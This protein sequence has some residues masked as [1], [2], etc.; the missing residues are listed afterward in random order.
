MLAFKEETLLQPGPLT[1]L[2]VIRQGIALLSPGTA[3]GRVTF[4]AGN[5]KR[6]A[7]AVVET[8]LRT[9][10][11]P[12]LDS[13]I[14]AWREHQPR[15]V[16]PK[17]NVHKNTAKDYGDHPE[18]YA[19]V[20]PSIE[21]AVDEINRIDYFRIGLL[22]SGYGVDLGAYAPKNPKGFYSPTVESKLSFEKGVEALE[23][24]MVEGPYIETAPGTARRLAT[25]RTKTRVYE[26]AYDR[27]VA[28]PTFAAE[29]DLQRLFEVHDSTMARLA[30]WNTF[31]LGTNGLTR[32]QVAEQLYPKLVAAKA[33]VG[34]S[35][36]TLRGRLTT[37]THKAR[38]L[39]V[40]EK[41][42]A[43]LERR[44]VKKVD[45][46]YEQIEKL[47]EEYGPE[48]SYLSGEAHALE[49]QI[50]ALGRATKGIATKKAGI[51]IP[52]LKADVKA[53]KER[54]NE[55]RRRYESSGT[56]RYQLN[57]D[58]RRWHTPT[59]SEAIDTFLS[60]DLGK[61]GT[62]ISDILDTVRA[63]AFFIDAS[64]ITIQ[65][66]L[67]MFFAPL[68][69]LRHADQIVSQVFKG[70]AL[71]QIA[72]AEPELVNAFARAQGRA[73]GFAGAEFFFRPIKFVN[74]RL[75]GAVEIARYNMWKNDRQ[76]LM[77]WGH[78]V[79]V[80]EAEAASANSK[81][82]PALNV[83]ERGISPARARV[84]RAPVV[85]PSFLLS[86]GLLMKDAASGLV[87][88]SLG[89]VNPVTAWTKLAGREQLALFRIM[90]FAGTTLSLAVTTALLSAKER[91]WTPG[92]AVQA[93][94][95]PNSPFFMS[96]ILGKQ[97][98]IAMGGPYRSFVRGLTPR[99]QDGQIIPMPALPN[100]VRFVRGKANPPFSATVD[101][102]RNRDY[103]GRK[104]LTEDYPVN[105][106]Q[107]L[108]YVAE[109]FSPLA[110]GAVSE[111]VRTG[112]F[113]PMSTTIEAISQLAGTSYREA[114]TWDRL[115]MKRDELAMREYG[116]DWDDLEYPKS[117]RAALE[118]KYPEDLV[119]PEPR[120]ERGL[121]LKAHRDIG[122]SYVERQESL[123]A[124]FPPGADWREGYGVLKD[125]QSGAYDAW[126]AANADVV[127]WLE[128]LG[129]E[130]PNE[131]ALNDYRQAFDDAKTAWGDLDIDKLSAILDRMEASWTP[132]QKTYVE[133]ET[134]IRDT[135]QV[136][137]Y[138]ADQRVL[139]PYWEI[140]DETWAD[141]RDQYPVYEPYATVDFFVQAQAQELLAMG[142][143]NEQLQYHL[144][145]VPAITHVLGMVSDLR[146]QYRLTNPEV[147][148]LL[149]KWGYVTT[150]AAMQD[151]AQ[152]KG[153]FEGSRF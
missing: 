153:R 105:V 92:E 96:L 73:F 129:S 119:R 7:A 57:Q 95:D 6:G 27:S 15:Y 23:R 121:A 91:G 24:G 51:D 88:L 58:T 150:P 115:I 72:K 1:S 30:G 125:Q 3:M 25:G 122:V 53:A 145:R 22:R 13:L 49:S 104:I 83:S 46:I 93:V 78:P 126:E 107:T 68:V 89:S 12:A 101:L 43:T 65:G 106:L 132:A 109:T 10:M 41:K 60:P 120:N 52:G 136:K 85:S 19:D 62:A 147:D 90:N 82:V 14:K 111:K 110:A 17:K 117:Q 26:G 152:P 76:L 143:P 131:K 32:L 47:G 139:R 50:E 118:K 141:L 94:V 67:A 9:R 2:P 61:V 80:A 48:L 64:L 87:K 112:E 59:E 45:P 146:F 44:A 5:A 34:K 84:E 11:K 70:E 133:R 140:M 42:L 114:T 33:E 37:A 127:S 31:R 77:K 151:R 39:G 128:T 79:N 56:G 29:T 108:W 75:G 102:I 81:M 113:D 100:L 69:T 142:V 35:L 144:S 137:E 86:P 8:Q 97:G 134:G 124:N 71:M 16:G 116:H 4:V 55:L 74:E 63:T 66:S 21:A 98:T 20:H 40:A 123:D 28:D 36:K 148:A 130:D 138:K 38:G 149:I 103:I 135:P 99:L 18:H 54:L